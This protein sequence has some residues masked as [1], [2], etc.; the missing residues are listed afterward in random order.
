[1]VAPRDS[2]KPGKAARS[3]AGLPPGTPD[4]ITPEL[5]IQTRQVWEP[6][7]SNPLTDQDVLE[8]LLTVGRLFDL[9]GDLHAN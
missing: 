6:R 5:L 8:I 7:Y 2:R 9:V 1:M 4:W 3:R